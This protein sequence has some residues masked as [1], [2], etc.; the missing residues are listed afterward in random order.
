M[1]TVLRGNDVEALC[2]IIIETLKKLRHSPRAG[3]SQPTPL[4]P[5]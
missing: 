2:G 3:Y 4:G 1:D 5:V